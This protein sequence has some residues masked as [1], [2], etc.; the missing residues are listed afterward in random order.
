MEKLKL[1]ECSDILCKFEEVCVQGHSQYLCFRVLGINF[2]L[3]GAVK[4]TSD[5]LHG[6]CENFSV[7][8]CYS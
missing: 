8:S 1:G 4:W 5:I 7:L 3:L 2:L 6:A